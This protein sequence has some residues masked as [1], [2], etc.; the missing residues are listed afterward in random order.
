M[1]LKKHDLQAD[2]LDA[3]GGC[4]VAEG[5]KHGVPSVQRVEEPH[6]DLSGQQQKRNRDGTNAK[7]TP[8]NKGQRQMQEFSIAS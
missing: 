3:R 6:S 8:P 1:A 4:R 5:V 2:F 7:A